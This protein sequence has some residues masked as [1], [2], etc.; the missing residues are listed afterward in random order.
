MTDHRATRFYSR[1]NSQPPREHDMVGLILAS[2]LFAVC[3][4]VAIT[5]YVG[6]E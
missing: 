5:A 1:L 2:V 3:V 6:K 4:G